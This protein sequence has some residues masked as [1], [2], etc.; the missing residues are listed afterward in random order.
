MAVLLE[1]IG[2]ELSAINGDAWQCNWNKTLHYCRTELISNVAPYEPNP[3][4]DLLHDVILKV[5]QRG[6]RPFASHLAEQWI[7]YLYGQGFGLH[8]NERTG[9]GRITYSHDG[10]PPERYSSFVDVLSP[11]TGDLHE[12]AF[13][14]E[15]PENEREVF[16]RLLERFGSR[17]AHCITPQAEVATLLP[18]THPA[19]FLT[20]EPGFFYLSLGKAG[21]YLA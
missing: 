1:Q 13:D 8:E 2:A 10:T 3:D 17:I 18:V 20:S 6:E 7:V 15:H 16:R 11:W 5:L 21:L 4:D 14:P 9:R 12:V 19:E